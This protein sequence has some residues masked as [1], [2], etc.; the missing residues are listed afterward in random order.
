MQDT[1]KT[2]TTAATTNAN[3]KA[4]PIAIKSKSR[5][6][7]VQVSVESTGMAGMGKGKSAFAPASTL[8]VDLP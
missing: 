4:A 5:P 7:K 8:D 2:P 6:F 3:K 1:L